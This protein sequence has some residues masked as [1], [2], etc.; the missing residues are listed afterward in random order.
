MPDK[1]PIPIH[2]TLSCLNC[3]SKEV[4]LPTDFEAPADT[5]IV[6]PACG[7][8]LATWGEVKPALLKGAEEEA[9]KAVKDALRKGF[10]DI[11]GFTIK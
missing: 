8:Q 3:G 2:A 5:P 10:E 9:K 1:I 7:K 4:C 6:C 11:D